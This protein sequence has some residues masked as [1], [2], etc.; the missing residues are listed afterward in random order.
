M[1][2]KYVE[3]MFHWN[4]INYKQEKETPS[5]AWKEAFA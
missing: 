3:L 1:M 5:K 4:K 2:F